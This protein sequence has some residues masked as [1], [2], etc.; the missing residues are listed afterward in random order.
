MNFSAVSQC[1]L[2]IYASAV[3]AMGAHVINQTGVAATAGATV[4]K[5][6]TGP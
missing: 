4:Q 3:C 5:L 6:M 1:K 2:L